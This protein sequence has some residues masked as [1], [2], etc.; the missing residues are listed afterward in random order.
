MFLSLT[1]LERKKIL[2]FGPESTEGKNHVT[3]STFIWLYGKN[4]RI[5][6]E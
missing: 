3:I 5:A 1:Q 4:Q 6:Q 2:S